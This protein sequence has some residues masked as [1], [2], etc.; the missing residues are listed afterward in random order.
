M[1]ITCAKLFVNVMGRPYTGCTEAYAQ[2]L[3]HC[4]SEKIRLDVSS[5]SSVYE[6]S[7]NQALVPSKDKIKNIKCRLLQF[8]FGALRI[9]SRL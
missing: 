6:S 4:V 5:E 2:S 9:K 8:L 3:C 7:E 1:T